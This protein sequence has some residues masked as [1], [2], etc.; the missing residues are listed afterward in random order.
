MS[1][2]TTM[3]V[4]V[5]FCMT[6]L[7]SGCGNLPGTGQAQAAVCQALEPIRTA[8]GELSTI[9]PTAT[10]AD[11]NALVAR[12]EEP[13]QSVRQR[14]ERLNITALDEL[15]ASYDSLKAR[16]D[17][18]ADDA[19]LDNAAAEIQAITANVQSALDQVDRALNCSR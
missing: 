2:H 10:S 1:R 9:E 6:F 7:L 3:M 11:V 8:I 16:V 14:S 18:L 5:G 4:V 13:I 19:T 17:E 15:Y 12:L